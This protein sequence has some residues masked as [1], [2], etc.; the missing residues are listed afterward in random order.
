MDGKV[1]KAV[2]AVFFIWS[3][4]ASVAAGYFYNLAVQLEE[5]NARISEELSAAQDSLSQLQEAVN[6][7]RESIGSLNST[8]QEL[9]QNYSEVIDRL[10]RDLNSG[11]V[12]LIIDFGN[13]TVKYY[14]LLVVYGENDTVF[15]LLMATGLEIDYTEYPEFNDVFINCIAGVCGMQT[16]E[17]SGMYWLFYVNAEMSQR[18]AKQ[19]T[20]TE[21]DVVEWVYKEVSW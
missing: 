18:G 11:Y 8:Y 3:I 9:L 12:S 7:L 13:G 1:F 21:G 5:E 19:T 17:N 15:D 16:S 4:L 20:V 6:S 14:K 2:I 10:A